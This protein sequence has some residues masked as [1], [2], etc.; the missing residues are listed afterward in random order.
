MKM[1]QI[2]QKLKIDKRK[3]SHGMLKKILGRREIDHIRLLHA[4]VPH[5]AQAAMR[6]GKKT[7]VKIQQQTIQAK[8]K[9]FG[10]KSTRKQ[11]RRFSKMVS[12]NQP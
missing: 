7:T 4:V 1:T 9:S 12:Y 5:L 2:A 11:G 10:G 8:S 6:L 3:E